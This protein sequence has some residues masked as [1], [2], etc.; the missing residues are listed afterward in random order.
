MKYRF[1]VSLCAFLSVLSSCTENSGYY[2]SF[3][4]S[5]DVDISEYVD[6]LIAPTTVVDTTTTTENP[7]DEAQR[8]AYDA[9]KIWRQAE[10][11]MLDNLEAAYPYTD[12]AQH[13]LIAHDGALRAKD[14][15]LQAVA[16]DAS[17]TV[18][19]NSLEKWI[20][21]L[22]RV[23]MDARR[24]R[25]SYSPNDPRGSD[26]HALCTWFGIYPSSP[27][28]YPPINYVPKKPAL[29]PLNGARKVC[30][31]IFFISPDRVVFYGKVAF[32]IDQ[33]DELAIS[34]EDY[35]F[36]FNEAKEEMIN[37]VFSYYDKWCWYRDCKSRWDIM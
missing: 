12:N 5:N 27:G 31:D 3:N 24:G 34:V 19:A 2:D 1:L 9:C 22:S 29:T 26:F 25:D 10:F 28:L 16:L 32:T 36:T 6:E 23:V 8:I 21:Y 7:A 35:T 17:Y 14:K 18:H 15:I 37:R 30:H 20:P 33:C 11:D 13:N 4:N